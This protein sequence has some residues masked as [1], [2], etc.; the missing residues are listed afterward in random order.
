[1][2]GGLGPTTDD[3]TREITA[4]LLGRE[5]APDPELASSI[6]QRLLRRGIRMT[7]QIL[8]QAKVP[9]GADVL[10]NE[11]GSAPG[12]YIAAG[13]TWR[14]VA[15]FVSPPGTAARVAADVWP[16]GRADTSANR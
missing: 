9:R 1:M 5:L 2:T 6:T 3:I 14:C 4:E 8:R 12:F 7:D 10:P 15:P 16:V 13:R 11:N